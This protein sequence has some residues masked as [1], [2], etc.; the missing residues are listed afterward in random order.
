M[1]NSN[2]TDVFNVNG[3]PF[4]CQEPAFTGCVAGA[5]LAAAGSGG[6]VLAMYVCYCSFCTGG[7]VD[8]ICGKKPT[9]NQN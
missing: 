4:R 7:H 3:G 5:I 1:E 2:L 8:E 6:G 9:G